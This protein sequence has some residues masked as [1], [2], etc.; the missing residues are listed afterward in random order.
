MCSGALQWPRRE[1]RQQYL[2]LGLA[3][4]LAIPRDHLVVSSAEQ[5]FCA[6][7]SDQADTLGSLM[8]TKEKLVVTA[9][10]SVTTLVVGECISSYEASRIVPPTLADCK[11]NI[12]SILPC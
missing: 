7:D 5:N 12:G 10:V 4:F 8:G 2:Y 3:S 6:E 1:A 9:F 11:L